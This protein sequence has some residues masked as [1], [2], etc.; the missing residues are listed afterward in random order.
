MLP[1]RGNSSKI[2]IKVQKQVVL[3]MHAPLP[4]NPFQLLPGDPQVFPEQV[5]HI[6]PSAGSGSPPGSLDVPKT[7]RASE[8][9]RPGRRSHN[10]MP[11]PTHPIEMFCH[12]PWRPTWTLKLAFYRRPQTLKSLSHKAL[13]PMRPVFVHNSDINGFR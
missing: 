4:S 12:H 10:Q 13:C 7:K 5:R 1:Q 3:R 11:E 9:R 6:I 8:G 2:Q